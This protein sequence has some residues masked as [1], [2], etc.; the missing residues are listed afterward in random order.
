MVWQPDHP[1]AF[2]RS[3]Q[4]LIDVTVSATYNENLEAT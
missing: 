1:A 2:F 4:A 3:F